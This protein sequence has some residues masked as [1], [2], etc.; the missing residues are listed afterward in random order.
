MLLV[1]HHVLSFNF[2]ELQG[3]DLEEHTDFEH[4]YIRSCSKTPTVPHRS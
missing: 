3:K 1:P 2:Y 4:V